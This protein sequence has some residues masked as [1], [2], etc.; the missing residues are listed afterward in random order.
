MQDIYRLSSLVTTD[1]VTAEQC[2]RPK[3][4][5]IMPE[6]TIENMVLGVK[7]TAL[8]CAYT[9]VLCLMYKLR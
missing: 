4:F 3:Y 7:I 5:S 9:C 8:S 1:R 2:L 6:C